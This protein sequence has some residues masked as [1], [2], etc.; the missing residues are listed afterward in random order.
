M[1]ERGES[2]VMCECGRERERMQGLH[3]SHLALLS[4]CAHEVNFG[5]KLNA[6]P[7]VCRMVDLL[8][9]KTYN[10]ATDEFNL[11]SLTISDYAALWTTINP[12]SPLASL[13]TRVWWGKG[14]GTCLG[15]GLGG[16]LG[17]KSP[18][19]I[20]LSRATRL[21]APPSVLQGSAVPGHG[22]VHNISV[23]KGGS[24]T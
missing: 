14:K 20:G 9:S 24:P 3:Q 4:R 15:L 2:D 21:V 11:T 1:S 8:A 23:S 12:V 22:N 17:L 19:I 7:C 5:H 18:G 6:A 10:P 13:A 16:G